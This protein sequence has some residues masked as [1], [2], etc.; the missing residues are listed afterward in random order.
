MQFNINWRVWL[1]FITVYLN[2][3]LSLLAPKTSLPDNPQRNAS[4][5][6][7]A[8]RSLSWSVMRY[9][10]LKTRS[11]CARNLLL[12]NVIWAPESGVLRNQINIRTKCNESRVCVVPNSYEWYGEFTAT[13]VVNGVTGLLFEDLHWINGHV[14]DVIT[15]TVLELY[16][17][18]T[19]IFWY[20]VAG[21][22]PKESS[23]KEITAVIGK[24]IFKNI[25][26]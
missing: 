6:G 25:Y 5:G 21:Y 1:H 26:T 22:N 10:C 2:L 3:E 12:Y 19:R 17:N 24:L 20:S 14:A 13:T 9:P 23:A 18:L 7:K 8:S 15:Q 16:Q 4:C 11:N